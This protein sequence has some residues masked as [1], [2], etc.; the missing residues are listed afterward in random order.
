SGHYGATDQLQLGIGARF[1]HNEATFINASGEEEK[2]TSTGIQ[3]TFDELHYAFKPVD[4]L[5]YALEGIYRYTPYTN[6]ERNADGSG[7]LIL[8]DDGNAYE[9][10]L[11]VTY[12][13]KS[14]DF[15][16]LRGGYRDPGKELSP[17]LYWQAE[18]ALVWKYVALVAGVDG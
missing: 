12:A 9:A 17:E 8:S 7:D 2:A 15:F 16:T 6:K 5:H 18:G 4:R 10:G 13:F 3:S 1:R 14:N 11:G